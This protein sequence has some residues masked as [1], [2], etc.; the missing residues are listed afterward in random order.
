M[1]IGLFHEF[2]AQLDWML[3]SALS[4]LLSSKDTL[5]L[6]LILWPTTKYSKGFDAV[7]GSHG[8][9]VVHTPFRAP[10]ANAYAE[11]WVRSVRAECLDRIILLNQWHLAYA[12]RIYKQYFNESRP[13]QGIKQRIPC[14]PAR[15]ST[16]GKVERRDLLGGVIHDYCSAVGTLDRKRPKLKEPVGLD[17]QPQL[18]QV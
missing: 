5:F 18:Q 6:C 3:L 4:V 16:T 15:R 1:K 2:V 7:F 9:D 10:R 8:V 13:H 17:E 12:L 11:R 14:P